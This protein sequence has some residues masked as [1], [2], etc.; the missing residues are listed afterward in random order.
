MVMAATIRLIRVVCVQ[1][2]CLADSPFYKQFSGNL[3]DLYGK[4]YFINHAN[5]FQNCTTTKTDTIRIFV[6]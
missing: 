6:L 3:Y 2:V 4:F 1:L 5:L